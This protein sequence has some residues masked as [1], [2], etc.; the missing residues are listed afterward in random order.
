VSPTRAQ[1][2]RNRWIAAG[3]AVLV[4][5]IVVLAIVLLS[6]GDDGSEPAKPEEVP[7]APL[8]GLPD[9]DGVANG[10]A[11]I[12]VK[13]NNTNE[14]T[15]AGVDQADVVYEEVVEGQYTRLAAI[16]NSHAPDKVGP[17]RSVRRTD[18]SIVWPIG[19][20]FVF[21]GG[22]PASLDAIN[23]APVIQ[24]DET[25]AGSM[26]FRDD[27][28]DAPVNLWAHVDQ[29]F[30]N[31]KDAEPVPPPALFSYRPGG[32]PAV[33]TP[34]ASVRV[35]FNAGFDV[36]WTWDS[37]QRAWTRAVGSMASSP[38]QDDGK[39]VAPKNVVVMKVNYAGG[40]GV[41]GSEAELTGSGDAIVFTAGREIQG[42]WERAT[43]EDVTTFVDTEGNEIR[44]TPGQTW[45]QLADV[46]YAVDVT[47]AS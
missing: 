45:V 17:V 41:E 27:S 13:V 36:T 7:T 10:R 19:G 22:A 28:A 4:V 43:V 26:M 8:T 32:A 34:I 46:S 1:I 21:S 15:Q 14:N 35:G 16:F 11:A 37:E 38:T 39:T 29:M 30:T 42:R 44:L 20:V 5:A 18:A 2:R 40:V 47:P 23:A 12:T 6:G 9:P 25:R 33:G 31:E 24:L 3:G